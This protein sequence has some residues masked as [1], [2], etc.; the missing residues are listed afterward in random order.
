MTN[1]LQGLRG[2]EGRNQKQPLVSY[3]PN[4]NAQA[5]A[6]FW[7]QDIRGN[8]FVVVVLFQSFVRVIL[9]LKYVSATHV[10]SAKQG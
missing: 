7:K 2:E 1:I 9:Y 10:E 6:E 8:L 4:A 3:Q 5:M